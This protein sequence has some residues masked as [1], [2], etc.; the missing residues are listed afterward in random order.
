MDNIKNGHI[1]VDTYV[2]ELSL[3]SIAYCKRMA[4]KLAWDI[5]IEN[6]TEFEQSGDW[7]RTWTVGIDGVFDCDDVY[8]KCNFDFGQHEEWEDKETIF[9]YY[10]ESGQIDFLI[11]TTFPKDIEKLRRAIFHELLEVYV[12]YKFNL[13]SDEHIRHAIALHF[14]NKEFWPRNT[15]GEIISLLKKR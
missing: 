5:C 3:P 15:E 13:W 10:R 1:S 6:S 11:Q 7:D 12:G 2:E 4:N 14:E 9:F 8:F